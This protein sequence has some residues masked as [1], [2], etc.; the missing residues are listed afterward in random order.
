MAPL[1]HIQPL[2]WARPR[3]YSNAVVGEGRCVFLAGQVGWDPTSAKPRFPKTFAAQFDQALSNVVTV[4]RAAG[5]TPAELTRVTLYV[6]NKR[7]YIAAIAHV[8]EAWRR[9][10]GRHYPAMTLVEVKG[11]LE[12]KA[13]VEIEATAVLAPTKPRRRAGR[14]R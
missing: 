5:G 7:E 13:K 14:G 8:G 6:V 12:P 3:G 10:I 11:L 2:G 1:E 9:H 4:L